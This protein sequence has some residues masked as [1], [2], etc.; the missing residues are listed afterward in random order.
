MN[1]ALI[2]GG[3]NAALSLLEQFTP[4]MRE[5]VAKGEISVEQQSVVLARIE[6]VRSGKFF[7]QPHWVVPPIDPTPTPP[8]P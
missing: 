4:V 3:V 2:L 5:M 7:D 1:P 6:L 8:A